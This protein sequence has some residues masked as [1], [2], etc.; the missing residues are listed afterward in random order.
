MMMATAVDRRARQQD[1]YVRG[2][3][4][5]MDFEL[6]SDRRKN[7]AF[8]TSI[9]ATN[10]AA[11]PNAFQFSAGGTRPGASIFGNG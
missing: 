10:G 11:P 2:H 6:E 8:A 1:D 4:S 3:Q 5:P 7:S 9:L